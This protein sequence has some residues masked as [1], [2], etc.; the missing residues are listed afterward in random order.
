MPLVGAPDPADHRE[1]DTMFPVESTVGRLALVDGPTTLHARLVRRRDRL[2]ARLRAGFLDAELARGLPPE[3]RWL[4]AV[5]AD[6][7][8]AGRERRRQSAAWAD[9]LISP[10]GQGPHPS[11]VPINRRGVAA[12]APQIAELAQRL[13]APGPIP[14]Q[15]VARSLRLLTDGTGPLYS[16]RARPDLAARVGEVLRALDAA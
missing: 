1:M 14:A 9:L 3:G 15:A 12:A 5:R 8:V 6:Q 13:A 10:A 4:R 7:L 2:A 11:R 16:R